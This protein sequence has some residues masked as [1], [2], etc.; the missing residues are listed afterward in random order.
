MA[1]QA[2]RDDERARLQAVVHGDVQGVGFRYWTRRRASELGLT[3]YVRNKWNG[4]VEV[5]AEGRRSSLQRLLDLLGQGPQSS[6]VRKV[7]AQW[8]LEVGR[9]RS[10]RVRY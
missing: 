10:F 3:G 2:Q 7:C 4:S 9:F 5:V 6:W 1:E 8:R